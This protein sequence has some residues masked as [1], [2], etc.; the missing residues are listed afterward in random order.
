VPTGR[1]SSSLGLLKSD[2]LREELLEKD[3]REELPRQD[4][5]PPLLKKGNLREEERFFY[6]VH[7]YYVELAQNFE[8]QI[9]WTEY[10]I[11]FASGIKKENILGVQFHPEKSQENGIKLLENWCS[12]V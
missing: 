4:Y 7:S 9:F 8:G 1:G 11:K 3:L 5:L 2:D 12:N 10:G 6:F